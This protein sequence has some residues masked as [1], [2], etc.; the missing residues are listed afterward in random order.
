MDDTNKQAADKF[1]QFIGT[2]YEEYKVKFE[3]SCQKDRYKWDEDVYSDTIVKCYDSICRNG[4]TDQSE[5]GM[6]NYFFR[7]FKTNIVR[8]TQYSRNTKSAEMPDN[9]EDYL[10]YDSA[11]QVRYEG[12][13]KDYK[14]HYLLGLAEEH[15]DNV[16]YNCFRLYRLIPK[17]T[18][19]K[20]RDL[21]GVKDCKRR[22][23]SVNKWLRENADEHEAEREFNEALEAGVFDA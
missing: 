10:E 14:V 4:L 21:T 23:T 1:L 8:E 12:M 3:Q 11:E 20:L 22:V 16:T 19:A 9:L 2:I 15:F 5:Q 18:Y 7:S 6:K 13:L 17:M